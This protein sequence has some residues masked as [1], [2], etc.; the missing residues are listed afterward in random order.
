MENTMQ[1]REALIDIPVTDGPQAWDFYTRLF[2]RSWDAQPT[3]SCCAWQV[4][5]DTWVQVLTDVPATR[6]TG[7][8]LVV[9]D[10][11]SEQDRLAQ[12]GITC[13]EVTVYPGFVQYC[14]V[15]DPE[16][17]VISLVEHLDGA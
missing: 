17:T 16:G 15:T 12:A 6:P 11:A 8:A 13:G 14:D 9:A 1:I 3:P 4:R 10:L 2:G 7:F 5:P